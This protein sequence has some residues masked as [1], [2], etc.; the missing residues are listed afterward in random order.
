MSTKICPECNTKNSSGNLTCIKCSK[1][2]IYA[3]IEA[4]WTEE[5]EKNGFKRNYLL[6]EFLSSSFIIRILIGITF[7]F[8]FCLS[9]NP[10]LLVIT[11]IV[12]GTFFMPKE[13]DYFS[14]SELF[15]IFYKKFVE[16]KRK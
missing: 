6:E 16:D 7:G 14:F 15:S 8:L 1:S 12:V 9:F 10:F 3:S 5:N 4:E 13:K 11:I 2:I